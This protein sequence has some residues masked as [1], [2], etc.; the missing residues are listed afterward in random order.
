MASAEGLTVTSLSESALITTEKI[1]SGAVDGLDR[2]EH[3]WIPRQVQTP[4]WV[5]ARSVRHHS[6]VG[7]DG[8]D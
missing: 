5:P 2:A 4:F 3:P 7:L 8:L 6:Y 1:V